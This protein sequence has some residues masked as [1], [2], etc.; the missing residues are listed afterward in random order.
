[1]P[2]ITASRQN[3]MSWRTAWIVVIL[4]AFLYLALPYALA[5][6]IARCHESKLAQQMLTIGYGS[7]LGFR[8]DNF[9]KRAWYKH[10]N[11]LI[12]ER[13]TPVTCPDFNSRIE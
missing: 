10:L 7:L 9:Y 2:R 11:R 3:L 5:S 13:V 1:M 6:A 12:N 4:T 8:A